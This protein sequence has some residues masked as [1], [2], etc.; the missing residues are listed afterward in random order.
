MSRKLLDR[1]RE[2][3][4]A[5]VT[6]DAAFD[7]EWD[8]CTAELETAIERGSHD[9]IAVAVDDF[10]AMLAIW[11]DPTVTPLARDLLQIQRDVA[12]NPTG[13]ADGDRRIARRLSLDPR[14]P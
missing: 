12:N 10:N 9:A 7:A 6:G 11:N 4:A 5:H 13:L 1:L 2:L 14:N 8:A 3:K